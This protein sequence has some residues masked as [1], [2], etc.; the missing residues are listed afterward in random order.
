MSSFSSI[1]CSSEQK[2]YSCSHKLHPPWYRSHC[3]PSSSP[4]SNFL[5]SC[6]PSPFLGEL[7]RTIPMMIKVLKKTI[8]KLAYFFTFF[9]NK[10]L[11][12]FGDFFD[13]TN[14]K[15]FYF[16]EL[17]I[18]PRDPGMLGQHSVMEL[19]SQPSVFLP[20]V[21]Q[22]LTKLSWLPLN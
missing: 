1:L 19:H 10:V 21:R 18:E 11:C 20:N 14:F 7:P 17:G 6:K 8:L 22:D 15:S 9:S 13:F 3:L 2:L 4:S 12:E 5:V 16:V